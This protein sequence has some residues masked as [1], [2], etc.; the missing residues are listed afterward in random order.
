M[1]LSD[2]AS[3][4]QLAYR[5]TPDQGEREYGEWVAPYLRS[6]GAELVEFLDRGGTQGYVVKIPGEGL[7]IAFRGTELSSVQDLR[8]NLSAA[9]HG[10]GYSRAAKCHLGFHLAC[11]HVFS[12]ILAVLADEDPGV[13]HITGHS[14][15]AGVASVCAERLS[16]SGR[17]PNYLV[18]FG[19]PRVGNRSFARSI[20]TRMVVHRVVNGI[21][22]VPYF[23]RGVH[24]PSLVYLDSQGV[25]VSPGPIRL[26]SS[27]LSQTFGSCLSFRFCRDRFSA[28]KITSYQRSLRV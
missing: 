16:R 4:C 24:P 18:T 6:M 3:F 25:H 23:G 9:W 8:M 7:L 12:R 5:A 19:S 27:V 10:V 22:P 15:G 2:Y 26:W 28:H 14:L 21:D 20:S 1:Q 11:D 17:T 13:L